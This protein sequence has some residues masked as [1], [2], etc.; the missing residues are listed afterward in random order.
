LHW[1]QVLIAR[2]EQEVDAWIQNMTSAVMAPPDNTNGRENT[3]PT[4][5]RLHS[6]DNE[7]TGSTSKPLGGISMPFLQSDMLNT[8]P[9]PFPLPKEFPQMEENVP[10]TGVP[11]IYLQ[12]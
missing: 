6:N 5:G 12:Q 7:S 8:I 11:S 10:S 1:Y 2:A 9:T 4:Q 3:M